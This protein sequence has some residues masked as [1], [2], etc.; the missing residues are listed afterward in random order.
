MTL[1]TLELTWQDTL[2]EDEVFKVHGK[3]AEHATEGH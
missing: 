3:K 2:S 1:Y